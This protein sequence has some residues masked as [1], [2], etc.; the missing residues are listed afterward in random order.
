MDDLFGNMP[1]SWEIALPRPMPPPFTSV[2]PQNF[3]VFLCQNS[4]DKPTI[5]AI[6]AQL[7]QQGISCWLDEE[8][9]P[10]GCNWLETQERDMSRLK[11]VAVF[12]GQHGIGKY[13]DLEIAIFVQE[14]ARKRQLRIIPV[15][16]ADAPTGTEMSKFLQLF[17]NS[18][19]VKLISIVSL[20]STILHTFT[21]CKGALTRQKYCMYDH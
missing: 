18:I 8:Q 20:V 10:P 2:P 1:Q 5:R 15:F 13:Q 16:L 19:L 21:I 3:D 6:A 12:V 17:G 4:K 14:Y 7:Q 9:L 11:A